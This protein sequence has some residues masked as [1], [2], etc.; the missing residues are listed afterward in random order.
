MAETTVSTGFLVV[1]MIAIV[2]LTLVLFVALF[3][4]GLRYTVASDPKQALDSAQFL[5]VL[6]VLTDAKL[7]SHTAVEV[8][9]NAENFYTAELE[10]IRSAQGSVNLE[11]YIFQ[12]G[13]VARQFVETLTDRARAGVR[14]NIVLDGMGSFGVNKKFFAQLIEAGG[15]VEWYNSVRWNRLPRYN[16][17]THRELLIIDGKVGFIGGAGIG[18]HWMFDKGKNRRWRD[19]MVRVECDAVPHLQATLAENWLEAS[20][21]V[22]NGEEYFPM[23]KADKKSA[24]LVVT[25]TPSAGGSTRARMLFQL[26]LSA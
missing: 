15:R 22:L 19:T 9:T 20:G 4:P 18:D 13:E 17:R 16:N 26:L 12:K 10:A 21:E 23:C 3:D 2:F 25:S 14:V 8:L 1:A 6:E 24:M 11:A 7:N 5:Y